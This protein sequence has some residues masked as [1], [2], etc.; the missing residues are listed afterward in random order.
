M[1]K[2]QILEKLGGIF[3][4][5]MGENAANLETSSENA[6][7]VDDLGLNSVGILYLVIAIEESF[8]IRFDDVGTSDLKTVGQ[9]VEYIRSKV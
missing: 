4:M 2:E 1:D 5:V 7:L 8:G 9:V 6:S 3:K